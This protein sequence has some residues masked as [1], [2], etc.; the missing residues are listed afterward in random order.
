MAGVENTRSDLLACG[1]E[2]QGVWY[3]QDPTTEDSE[4]PFFLA[5][6]EGNR[7]G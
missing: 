6:R 3:V 5:T 7:D 1:F 2:V 4:K